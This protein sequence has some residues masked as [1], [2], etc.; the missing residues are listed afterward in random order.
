M[1]SILLKNIT[2]VSSEKTFSADILIEDGVI[3]Y[4]SED[5][6]LDAYVVALERYLKDALS[7]ERN[8]EY[9]NAN[10]TMAQCAKK[11]L[12]VYGE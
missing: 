9:F 1:G 2:A 11:Y 7:P 3:G 5:V 10:F 12:E 8:I 6:S 4:L